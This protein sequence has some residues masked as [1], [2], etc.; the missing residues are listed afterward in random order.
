MTDTE[1][2]EYTQGLRA[3]ADLIDAHPDLPQP[4][5][6]AHSSSNTVE[7]KWYL[8]IWADDLTEQ[9]ATAAAIV[10]TLGGRWDKNE[11]TYDDGLEFVQIRDGLSLEVVVNRAAVCERVVVGTHEVTVPAAPEVAARPS[12]AE[13]VETVEDV[14]WICSSLLAESV[15]A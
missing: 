8:H 3:I 6:S 2:P 14:Q 9:K 13:R 10:S 7:A 1:R 5:I 12:T 15:P 4:Y 11:R